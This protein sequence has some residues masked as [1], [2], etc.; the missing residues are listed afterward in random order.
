MEWL[1]VGPGWQPR[2]ES[3]SCGD[4]V[5]KAG[6]PACGLGHSDTQAESRCG[7]GTWHGGISGRWGCVPRQFLGPPPNKPAHPR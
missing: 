1:A 6:V 5:H 4:P 7:S 3:G 2:G